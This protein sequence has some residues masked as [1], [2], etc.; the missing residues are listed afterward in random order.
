MPEYAWYFDEDDKQ[1]RVR[2]LSRGAYA[3]LVA[4]RASGFER[5]VMVD[6]DDIEFIDGDPID[7]ED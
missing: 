1:R 6:N 5:T 7:D 3:S 4:Y 2:V